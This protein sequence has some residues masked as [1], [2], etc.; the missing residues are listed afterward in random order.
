MVDLAGTPRSQDFLGVW[1]TA[2]GTL[3]SRRHFWPRAAGATLWRSLGYAL[4]GI[5]VVT[6]AAGFI[7]AATGHRFV[8]L[9]VWGYLAIAYAALLFALLVR[10]T[11]HRAE[12]DE[13][14][15]TIKAKETEAQERFSA[16]RYHLQPS[17]F[18]GMY[19]LHEDDSG[20]R[21]PAY[22]FSVEFSNVGS[23]P[24]EFEVVGL[25]ISLGSYTVPEGTKY[26]WMGGLILSGVPQGFS[27]ENIF[28]PVPPKG[29]LAPSGAGEYTVVYGHPAGGP[30]FRM[31][32]L[33]GIGWIIN[34]NGDLE[35]N[36]FN[37]GKVTDEIVS[38]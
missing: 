25:G 16:V 35:V 28:A 17:R 6:A 27:Y 23:D 9:P 21:R 19:G 7:S 5:S 12:A 33:F 20:T 29:K 1:S 22:R 38:P 26:G 8:N 18:V 37:R 15:Q 34:G 13:L 11:Q 32:H 31:H 4:V 30:K 36:W 3:L 24:I 14:R 2:M 10:E